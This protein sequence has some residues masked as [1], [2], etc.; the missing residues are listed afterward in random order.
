MKGL[1]DMKHSQTPDTTVPG[2]PWPPSHL[3]KYCPLVVAGKRHASNRARALDTRA[4]P[5]LFTARARAL[6]TR[7]WPALFTAAFPLNFIFKDNYPS[8]LFS[9]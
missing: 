8:Q 1:E 7:A 9:L 6:D 4:W 2:S 5:A 3:S